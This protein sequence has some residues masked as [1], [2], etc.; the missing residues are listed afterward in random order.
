MSIYSVYKT[1]EQYAPKVAITHRVITFTANVIENGRRRPA[2]FT[3]KTGQPGQL[4]FFNG[5]KKLTVCFHHEAKR[6]FPA[7]V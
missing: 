2:H 4:L 1:S 5:L 6:D 7:L 3:L